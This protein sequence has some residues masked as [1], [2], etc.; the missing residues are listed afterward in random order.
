M[1]DNFTLAV[2]GQSLIHHDTRNIRCP[3]FD[4]VKAILKGADLAFTNFE[5]TIYGS[6]GGWPMKGYW[7][8][9]SKPFVLDSLDETGFKALSLSNNHSFDLGPSGILSTL[10]EVG[11]RGFLHAGI[12]RNAS[13]ALGPAS[14]TFGKRAVAMVAMDGGPGD[15]LM[16]AA[17][18]TDHRPERPGINRLRMSRI[19]DV[20]AEA[21]GHL[22][23]ILDKAGYSSLDLYEPEDQPQL[24]QGELWIG[25]AAFR[26]SDRFERT[27]FI[28]KEDLKNNLRAIRMAA[29]GG[30]LVI[31]YLHHHH[32]ASHWLQSPDWISAFA[33]QCID[34]GAAIFV[35][36][37][38]PVLLP[39]EIYQGRPIFHSLGNFIF[40]S[41]SDIWKPNEVWESAVGLCSFDQNHRLTSLTLHPV[42]LGGEEGLKD[43]VLQR[44]LVPHLA[45]GAAADR[46]LGRVASAS[47]AYG[48]RI[49]VVEGAGK[50]DLV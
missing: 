6:H 28:D 19:L 42:I 38:V 23:A 41:R 22:K 11:K 18:A 8:G 43:E 15:D 20:D 4:R 39:I 5:G 10:D 7:F 26:K 32:W 48:S 2:T 24:N 34:A 49:E 33:R 25:R 12:G 36:H 17:D 44:R 30:N 9:S 47:M 21:F 40:H 16:Y 31:A 14:A 13:E 45:T 50:F 1:N 27:V 3:E 37:G 29:D 35:S 46:I